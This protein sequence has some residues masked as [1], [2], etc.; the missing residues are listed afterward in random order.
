VGSWLYG[1]DRFVAYGVVSDD[2]ERMDAYW[3]TA[4]LILAGLVV[5][6]SL[7]LALL[8]WEHRRYARSCMRGL[9]PQQATGRVALFAPCKGLDLD[10]EANLHALFRQD[11][12]NYEIIF[13]VENTDDPAYPAIR[14]ALAEYPWVPA[15]VIAAGRATDSGQKVHNLRVATEHL[16][17]RIKYL[18]F[19]DSDARPRPEW[20]RTLVSR[21]ERPGLG[22]VTGYRWFTP[23][24][25]T[26]ANALVYSMNCDVIS[27]LTR[28]SHHLIWGGSWALRRE[29]FDALDLR[30]AWKGTLSDDL[31]ASRL[32]RQS[33]LEVRFEPACVVASPLD[34]SLGEALAFIRRQYLV[35]RL[36]TFDW[37]LFSLLGATFSN[38]IWLG[39]LGVLIC[40]LLT[41]SP[42][43]WIPIAVSAVLYLVTVY[44]GSVRQ[45]LVK[46]YFPHWERASRR[47]RSFDIWANPLVELAHWVG[48][49]SAAIGRYVNWR[50][51]RYYV[52]PGGQLQKIIRDDDAADQPAEEQFFYREAG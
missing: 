48:V 40:G 15:R 12:D 9:G 4:Y 3:V 30:N 22:A 27:L 21:L 10:F 18:A 31:V 52:I 39:N 34:V 41:G 1:K 46:T 16:S 13:I 49:A 42:S 2:G 6:E 44:R 33:R 43:P 35:A 20:L 11:Y 17:Q 5:V 45:D 26:V 19:V 36:Y 47:I 32:M 25:P 38:A 8:T 51:I 7:L 28:S 24:R 50:G 23:A 29:V 37:W 14:R